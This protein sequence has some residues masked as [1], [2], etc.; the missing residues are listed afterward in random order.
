[1]GTLVID[2][3]GASLGYEAGAL[4]IRVP[5][6]RPRS[7]P[8]RLLERL[9][10]AGAVQIDSALLT[11]LAEHD[12]GVLALPARG[13]R[14]AAFLH[15]Q[16][17]GDASRRLGQYRLILDTGPALD[18]ARRFVMFRILG[19]RRLLRRAQ[20]LRPD[21]RLAL[22]RGIERLD[23]ARTQARN[24]TRL[25]RLRG[26]EGAAAAG[27]FAAYTTLFAASLDFSGRNRRPPRDPIN[28]ALSLGYTLAHGEAIQALTR[29]GLDPMLGFL[30]EPLHNRES[31]ACDLV[32]I[33]RP[34]IEQLVWRLFADKRLTAAHF[35]RDDGA[36][37]MGKAARRIF[38]AAY[39]PHA[40]LHRR[41]F[42]RYARTLA[43]AC[44]EPTRTNMP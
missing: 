1:M 28:A 13:H 5:D 19:S 6:A 31:L 23:G 16:S 25:E 21:R 36:A 37:R 26:I 38:F 40:R 11:H 14:R 10:V 33:A 2:Q 29:A 18:W 15:G 30:H 34:R 22:R 17:H 41:G 7:V 42:R 43:A 32:E 39:E 12:I 35:S 44:Y 4:M 20:I 24:T 9:V 8:L 3:R 27:Y